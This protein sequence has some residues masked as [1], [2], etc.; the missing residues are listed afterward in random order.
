MLHEVGSDTPSH[1]G[2]H[3]SLPIELKGGTSSLETLENWL[4]IHLRKKFRVALWLKGLPNQLKHGNKPN[5]PKSYMKSS[6]LALNQTKLTSKPYLGASHVT[7]EGLAAWLNLNR[8]SATL[9]YEG[10]ILATQHAHQSNGGHT[11]HV[12]MH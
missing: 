12:C 4:K 6:C 10:K 7:L 11:M 2:R 3:I 5:Y 9:S 1:Q 8:G